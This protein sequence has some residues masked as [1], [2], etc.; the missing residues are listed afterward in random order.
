[1]GKPRNAKDIFRR[2]SQP[3]KKENL[4]DRRTNG[5]KNIESDIG[6]LLDKLR[7]SISGEI[8]LVRL[9]MERFMKTNMEDF[10]MSIKD[11]IRDVKKEVQDVKEK[12]AVPTDSPPVL[13]QKYYRS[14]ASGGAEGKGGGAGKAGARRR[15]GVS[16]GRTGERGIITLLGELRGMKLYQE[17]IRENVKILK[18]E[19]IK[20]VKDVRRRVKLLSG[21]VH[22]FYS[23]PF[24]DVDSTF[25]G[26]NKCF[27][28]V[29]FFRNLEAAVKRPLSK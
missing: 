2:S 22:I 27:R 5:A 21:E 11:E 25:G 13:F 24:F 19:L 26:K 4:S 29:F 23:R 1:M 12:C 7:R 9:S 10:L 14:P 15:A 18:E 6:I 8:N 3:W 20:D 16:G 28:E 17:A